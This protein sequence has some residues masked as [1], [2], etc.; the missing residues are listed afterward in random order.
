MASITKS[1]ERKS[2]S[3]T[4]MGVTSSRPY[5]AFR[6]S[7]LKQSVPRRS[8]ISSKSYFPTLNYYLLTINYFMY[9][10]AYST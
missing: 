10:L 4:H 7:H 8:I 3:A 1:G 9:S 6:A 2:M 5:M